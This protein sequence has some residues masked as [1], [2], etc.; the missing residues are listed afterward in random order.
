MVANT[1]L[2]PVKEEAKQETMIKKLLVEE[3]S[4]GSIPIPIKTGFVMVPPP[5]PQEHDTIPAKIPI[6]ET[7]IGYF[8]KF[9]DISVLNPGINFFF[10]SDLK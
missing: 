9:S 8:S 7:L 6:S 2:E 10:F 3:L 1:N 4:L 5:I